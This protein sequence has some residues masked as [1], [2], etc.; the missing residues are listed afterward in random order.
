MTGEVKPGGALSGDGYPTDGPAHGPS[1]VGGI[2][3]GRMPH[4]SVS[5]GKD[6]DSTGI[7]MYSIYIN[8]NES[9]EQQLRPA[10]IRAGEV[11]RS[12]F[13]SIAVLRI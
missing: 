9:R 4:S 12:T 2:D 10:F 11:C 7:D 5:C 8:V 13:S 1:V 3:P 6:T